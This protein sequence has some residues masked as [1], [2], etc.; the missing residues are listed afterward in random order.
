MRVVTSTLDKRLADWS[1]LTAVR[2]EDLVLV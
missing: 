1:G 2:I